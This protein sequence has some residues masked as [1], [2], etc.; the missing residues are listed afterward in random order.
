MLVT[1]NQLQEFRWS[2]EELLRDSMNKIE[3]ICGFLS[4]K[5]Q[6]C[7]IE[8]SKGSLELDKKRLLAL[9][10][11]EGRMVGEIHQALNRM[12]RGSYG[13][14]VACK[15][16]ISLRRLKTYPTARFCTQCKKL[17]ENGSTN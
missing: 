4:Q 2:L 17:I 9:A 5:S 16:Q 11:L 6:S 1:Q 14:C 3:N 7:S 15:G 10:D 13:I 8:D 12:D